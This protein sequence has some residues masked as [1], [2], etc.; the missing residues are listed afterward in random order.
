MRVLIVGGG[1]SGL[2][3]AYWLARHGFTPSVVER[4]PHFASIGAMTT[5]HGEGVHVAQEMGIANGLRERAFRQERQVLRDERGRVLRT[6]DVRRA[7]ALH[8]GTLTL[9]R[10]AWHQAIHDA[11]ADRV[12]VQF[13]TSITSL[14]Q[15][16]GGVDVV[17]SDGVRDRF[18]IV[19]GADGIHSGVR[20]LAFAGEFRRRLGLGLMTFVLDGVG[21]LPRDLGLDPYMVTEWFLPGRY[22]EITTL[23][24]DTVAGIF[25]YPSPPHQP[26]L[27]PDER[28]PMLLDQFG[29]VPGAPRAIIEAVPDPSLIYSDELAQ[30]LLPAWSTGRVVLLG[31][32][33]W[34]LRPML[35]VGGGKAMR[36][37]YAL[38]QELARD[39]GYAAAFARYE[40]AMRP[41]ITL[42]QKETLRMAR[43]ALD[44]RPLAMLFKKTLFRLMPEAMVVRMRAAS[45]RG[46]AYE[47]S[48]GAG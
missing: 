22:I 41:A 33:A 47:H 8:G 2:T 3:L 38:A 13:G 7:H 12:P 23:S 48:N 24:A 40:R 35:G 32:A 16:T 5:M 31:D 6:F 19:V 28:T 11:V 18:D 4:A 27:A 46:T 29:H 9:R 34:A 39:G 14:D 26:S 1:I 30:V 15:D 17:L 36:G 45:P 10:S 42:L 20:E 21:S 25:V 44:G 43:F 37:A